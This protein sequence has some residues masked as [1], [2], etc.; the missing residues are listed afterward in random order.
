MFNVFTEI[1]HKSFEEEKHN[2]NIYKSNVLCIQKEKYESIINE[3]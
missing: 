1:E 3:I 2:N